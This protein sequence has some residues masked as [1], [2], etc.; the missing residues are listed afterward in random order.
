MSIIVSKNGKDAKR[1]EER[2]EKKISSV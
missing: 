1:M 2:I